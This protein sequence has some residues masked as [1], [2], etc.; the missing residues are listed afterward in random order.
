V[1]KPIHSFQGRPIVS[2]HAGLTITRVGACLGAEI[3]GVDLRKAI[4]NELGN[5]IEDALVENELIIL[6]NQ[7]ISTT[8]AD[9]ERHGIP[10]SVFL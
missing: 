4:S 7:D 3:T 1:N 9:F 8:L 5:A 2:Q 10:K 6:R